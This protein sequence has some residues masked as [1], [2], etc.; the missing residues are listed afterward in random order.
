MTWAQ[1]WSF[2]VRHQRALALRLAPGATPLAAPAVRELEL[3]LCA[4]RFHAHRGT[5]DAETF[6]RSAFFPPHLDSATI[7]HMSSEP[8]AR[9][10]ARARWGISA[11]ET[12]VAFVPS[13]SQAPQD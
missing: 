13:R 11:R 4:L 6:A 2:V 1:R 5:R 12:P 10:A 8:R 7:T 3:S 9:V